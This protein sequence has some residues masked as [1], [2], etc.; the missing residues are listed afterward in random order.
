MTNMIC[1]AAII[2]AGTA[3]LAAERAA[4]QAGA[5]TLLIDD[6]FTGTTCATVGCMPSKLLIAAANAAHNIDRAPAFGLRTTAPIV[7]GQ[8]VMVRLRKERDAFVAATLKSIEHLPPGIC[9]QQR[10]RFLS[11]TTLALGDGR[12]VSAKAVV[13]A[14]GARPSIPERFKALGGLVLTNET[15]FELGSLPRSI[16]VVGAGPLGLELAQA[17]VRL[18]VDV[19]VFEQTDHVA[20]LHDVEVANE[21]KLI[22]GAEL[23]MHFNARL[24]VAASGHLARIEWS[25]ASSGAKSFE[26]VL[27]AAGR[28]PALGDLNLA[29]SGIPLDD[30]GVPQVNDTTLQCGDAPIFLAGDVDGSR[31]VLHEAVF[32]GFLAGRNAAMFPNVQK[33]KRTVPLS[34]CSPTLLSPSWERHQRTRASSGPRLM[35]IRDA[36]RASSQSLSSLGFCR[37]PGVRARQQCDRPSARSLAF[38]WGTLVSKFTR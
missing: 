15:V 8:A 36:P 31:P 29:A 21:L 30:R 20:A 27:V 34:P 7:D 19:E 23:P 28:A 5:K 11:E 1:D 24:D 9:V 26:R 10:A 17:F 4:R 18:G 12:T 14:T 22:L 25:G 6:C 2:G 3:G 13:V 38:P 16:A 32:E 35:P 33:S 37:L